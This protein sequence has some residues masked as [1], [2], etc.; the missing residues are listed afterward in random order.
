MAVEELQ[1]VSLCTV[2]RVSGAG[3]GGGW[4][5]Q[6]KSQLTSGQGM[7]TGIAFLDGK[8]IHKEKR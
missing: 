5:T 2:R 3:A 6:G 4:G 1:E 8:M 7:P